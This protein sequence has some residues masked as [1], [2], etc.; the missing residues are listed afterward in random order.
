MLVNPGT[1][2]SSSHRRRTVAQAGHFGLQRLYGGLA[3]AGAGVSSALGP[4]GRLRPAG[5]CPPA[6]QQ[7]GPARLAGAEGAGQQRDQRAAFFSLR[8]CNSS[9]TLPPTRCRQSGASAL[10]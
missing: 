4:G 5:W 3:G 10:R 8:F 1:R 6:A 9:K 2:P 7:V